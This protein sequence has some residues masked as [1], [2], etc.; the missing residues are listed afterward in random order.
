VSGREKIWYENQV[1]WVTLP[2][3]IED[4]EEEPDDLWP[5]LMLALTCLTPK[6]RFV[7][8]CR[9]GLRDGRE[10]CDYA[11]IA[12]L[13]GISTPAAKQLEAR[14]IEK[15]RTWVNPGS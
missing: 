3:D 15:M 8:E 11:D 10:P 1:I 7:I 13:M 5:D 9:Y 14:A 6:Q 2:D 12:D 4:E